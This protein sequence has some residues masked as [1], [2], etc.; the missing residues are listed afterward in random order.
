VSVVSLIEGYHEAS[1][2]RNSICVF[3]EDVLLYKIP[4]LIDIELVSLPHNK[5]EVRVASNCVN[6][7]PDFVKISRVILNMQVEKHTSQN[8]MIP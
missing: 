7:I 5:Y 4:E 3:S 1:I 6:S 8:T 2:M